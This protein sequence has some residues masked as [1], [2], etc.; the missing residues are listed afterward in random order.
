MRTV[1]FIDAF[2][3]IDKQTVEHMGFPYRMLRW[4][5]GLSVT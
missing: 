5:I 1:T 2:G 3:M 4:A